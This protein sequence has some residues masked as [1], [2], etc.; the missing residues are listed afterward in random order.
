[1]T[2][3]AIIGTNLAAL[4]PEKKLDYLRECVLQVRAGQLKVILCPYCGETN[5]PTNEFLCCKTFSDAM[6]AVLHRV[7]EQDKADFICN[8]YDKATV[9]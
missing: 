4:S 8:V 7:E 2:D 5:F 1:M 3:T 9:N 6:D